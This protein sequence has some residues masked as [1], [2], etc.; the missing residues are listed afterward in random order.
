MDASFSL[1]FNEKDQLSRQ[2]TVEIP[3]NSVVTRK[4][5]Q[6]DG[7]MKKSEKYTGR[8]S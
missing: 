5:R 3:A 8:G 2:V 6:N 1:S 4:L 7:E